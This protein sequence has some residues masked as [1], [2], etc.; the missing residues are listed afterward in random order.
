MEKL[1]RLL[2]EMFPDFEIELDQLITENY[3]VLYTY[4]DVIPGIDLKVSFNENFSQSASILLTCEYGDDEELKSLT[5]IAEYMKAQIEQIN[6]DE[7]VPK[8]Q[9]ALKEDGIEM[10]QNFTMDIVIG[11]GTQVKQVFPLLQKV[12]FIQ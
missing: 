8:V 2:N 4:I 5:K 6:I 11:K 1:N 9:D 12:H 7:L 10:S 3:K